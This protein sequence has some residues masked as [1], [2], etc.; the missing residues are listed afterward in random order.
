MYRT[1]ANADY[2][3]AKASRALGIA[4]IA[5]RAR[6][7]EVEDGVLWVERSE[8]VTA[9]EVAPDTA[10]AKAGI[11]RGDVLVAVNGDPVDSRAEVLEYQHLARE[12]TRLT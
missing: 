7:H 5:T 4:N 8:G 2:L 10:A 11:E 6:L 9:V 1:P 12:G 3:A